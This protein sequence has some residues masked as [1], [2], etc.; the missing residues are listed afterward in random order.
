MRGTVAPARA[1]RYVVV[2]SSAFQ[3]WGSGAT[4]G[5]PRQREEDRVHHDQIA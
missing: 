1:R 4:G 5:V 2:G 3:A